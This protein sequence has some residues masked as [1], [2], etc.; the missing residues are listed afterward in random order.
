MKQK[1][2]YPDNMNCDNQFNVQEFTN[3]LTKQGR[4]L[5]FFQPE[6]SHKNALIERF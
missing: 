6:Q 4:K 1:I 3:F 2:A 5:Y